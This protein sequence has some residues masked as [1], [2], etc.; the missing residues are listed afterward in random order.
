[1]IARVFEWLLG[2]PP[3]AFERG[4]LALLVPWPAFAAFAVLIGL[5]VWYPLGYRRPAGRLRRRERLLLA[6]LRAAAISLAL[7]CLLRPQL[8]VSLVVPQENLVG[9][10]LD[11]SA[12][13]Q[14]ADAGPAAERRGTALLRAFP[15]D[16]SETPDALGP[17]LDEK[18]VTRL[19][20]FSETVERLD[21]P[22]QLAFRGARTDLGGA[23]S[24][25]AEELA[26]MPLAGLVVLTDGADTMAGGAGADFEEVLLDLRA[27]GVRVFPVVIGLPEFETDLE[28]GP[29]DAPPR[30]LRGSLLEVRVPL[31]ARGLSGRTARLEVLDE[32]RIAA[33]ETV[34]FGSDRAETTVTVLA[35]VEE[36]GARRLRFRVAPFPGEVMTRNNERT[37]LVEVEDRTVELLYFEGQP[38]WEM[39]FLRR[40]VAEDP[41]LRVVCLVRTAEGKFYRLDVA[42]AEELAGGFPDTREE[43][44]RYAGVVLGSVEA[45]FFSQDQL[46]MLRDLVSRRG[47][48]LLTLGGGSA[49]SEGGY[50]DTPL[51]EILPV[52]LPE[53]PAD[54]GS[55][56]PSRFREL[57]VLPTRAGLS[58]PVVRLDA[59][60]ALNAERYRSLPPLSGVNLAAAA[61]PGAS[62]LL[63]GAAPDGATEPVLLS[64]RFGRGRAASLTVQDLW[65]WQMDAAIAVEDETQELLWRRLLRWLAS[66]A[67]RRVELAVEPASALVGERVTL[68]AEVADERFLAV[69]DAIVEAVVTAPDGAAEVVPLRWTG[70]ADGE[71]SGA[72]RTATAG[73]HRVETRAGGAGLSGGAGEAPGAVPAAEAWFEAGNV[74]DEFFDAEADPERLTRIAEATGGRVFG[75]EEAG[76]LVADLSLADSGAT[77]IER[78]EL[79]N[80]PAMFLLLF[81]L[82]AAEW[83]FRSLRGL[84]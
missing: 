51:A 75:L 69:N 38:R 49:Y 64:Q 7:L 57:Q 27:R 76:R 12:S 77:V 56:A 72:Y 81:G 61:K 16:P 48:G 29:P 2:S 4:E 59:D 41:E 67:P 37:A 22:A 19:F 66:E 46:N 10:L 6:G 13:M 36:A 43:L 14:I 52:V 35:P 9:V 79:W 65:V 34:R 58:H 45:S 68:R 17:R 32:G 82:L 11:D 31:R 42:D 55:E 84:P 54:A 80:V 39:K 50:R 15:A 62:V 70:L 83:C 74:E 60:G 5:A 47:G 25:A 21:D 24:R 28:L 18:F 20:R 71:Y 63:E 8:V 44:F 78:R 73:V 1:M 30:V 40:A 3:V 53:P 23:L 33:A 26:S